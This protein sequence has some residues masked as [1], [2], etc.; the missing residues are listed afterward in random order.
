MFEVL[1]GWIMM[2]C[3]SY[4]VKYI[5]VNLFIMFSYWDFQYEQ[6]Y[7]DCYVV[8]KDDVVEKK[9]IW[10]FLFS[11]FELYGYDLVVFWL[12]GLE[13]LDCGLFEFMFWCVEV[14]KF[15]EMMIGKLVCVWCS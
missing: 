1:K 9:C 14:L 2:G 6:I 3:N 10:D 11:I 13:L 5:V 4:K 15:V 8:W 12:E 7:V